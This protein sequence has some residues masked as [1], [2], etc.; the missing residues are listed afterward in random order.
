MEKIFLSLNELKKINNNLEKIKNKDLKEVIEEIN[1]ARLMGDLSENAEYHSA[2]KK[3]IFIEEKIKNIEKILS[4][5]EIIEESNFKKILKIKLKNIKNN[6]VIEY[7][8]SKI[9]TNKK[10]YITEDSPI[11]IILKNKKINDIIK[12]KKYNK[13]IVYKIL[14]I[15]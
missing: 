2:K 1:Q 3:K 5:S 10:N 12:I 11:A 13:E 14:S 15:E 7:F 8:I 9:Q 4:N 6:E